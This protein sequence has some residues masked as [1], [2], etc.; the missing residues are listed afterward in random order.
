[1]T[2]SPSSIYAWFIQTF[3]WKIDISDPE[4]GD[5]ILDQLNLRP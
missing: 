4:L 1:M 3:T 5:E 2:L